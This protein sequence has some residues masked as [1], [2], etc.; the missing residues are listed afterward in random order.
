MC[1]GGC[2]SPTPCIVNQH[3]FNS[4][5][6]SVSQRGIQLHSLLKKLKYLQNEFSLLISGL[7][8][9]DSW[10]KKSKQSLKGQCHEIFY[11]LFSW[12]LSIFL[13]YSEDELSIFPNGLNMMGNGDVRVCKKLRSIIDN[14]VSLTCQARRCHWSPTLHAVSIPRGVFMTTRSH[15]AVFIM[16]S[17]NF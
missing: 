3:F 6:R 4:T 1:R 14:A 11:S 7:E 13:K 17:G 8:G 12:I 9:L 2:I 5:P 10:Q 16:T 15:S